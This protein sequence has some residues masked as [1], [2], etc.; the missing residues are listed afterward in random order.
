[1]DDLEQ[2]NSKDD[3]IRLGMF[4]ELAQDERDNLI[5]RGGKQIYYNGGYYS[6]RK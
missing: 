5:G 1:M 2:N 4:L 6:V 3:G